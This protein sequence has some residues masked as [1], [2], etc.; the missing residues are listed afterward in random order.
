MRNRAIIVIS[1]GLIVLTGCGKAAPAV[2]KTVVAQAAT[3]APKVA[4]A[5]AH[6]PGVMT[7][8]GKEV[9]GHAVDYGRKQITGNDKKGR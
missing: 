4:P 5:V 8:V 1:L 6:K 2:I 3:V 9:A 7:E